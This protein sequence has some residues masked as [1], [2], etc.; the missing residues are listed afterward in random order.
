MLRLRFELA[1]CVVA[2]CQPRF[3]SEV[4]ILLFSFRVQPLLDESGSLEYRMYCFPFGHARVFT[5]AVKSYGSHPPGLG[6]NL[7]HGTFSGS[8]PEDREKEILCLEPS[9]GRIGNIELID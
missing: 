7:A 1:L 3:A 4:A 6:S 2:S 9:L 5:R 8:S